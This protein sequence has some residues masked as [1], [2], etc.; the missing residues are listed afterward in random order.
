MIWSTIE[1]LSLIAVVACVIGFRYAFLQESVFKDDTPLSNE[2]AQCLLKM[3]SFTIPEQVYIALIHLRY[4]D[5]DISLRA[6]YDLLREGPCGYNAYCIDIHI[7]LILL[8]PCSTFSSLVKE[9]E[10]SLDDGSYINVIDDVRDILLIKT[11]H[12]DM[13]FF[14]EDDY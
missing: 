13:S 10:D 2:E 14:R 12:Y 1:L 11:P 5:S 6:V 7:E 4:V 3:G 9:I 8:C